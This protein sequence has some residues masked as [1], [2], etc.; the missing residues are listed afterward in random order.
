MRRFLLAI[1]LATCACLA[2]AQKPHAVTLKLIR[3][4]KLLE[5]GSEEGIDPLMQTL[6]ER[7]ELL[8]DS[9]CFGDPEI[10]VARRLLG[11]AIAQDPQKTAQLLRK[12]LD[13]P[14]PKSEPEL[15]DL[16][17]RATTFP[18]L[19]KHPA[20]V[21]EFVKALAVPSMIEWAEKQ[22]GQLKFTP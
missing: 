2:T 19:R 10:L 12:V 7:P 1:L 22:I 14:Y 9:P 3:A 16:S 6:E 17:L 5:A 15:T 18:V 20:Q 21:R 4:E 13:Q 11:V 8:I